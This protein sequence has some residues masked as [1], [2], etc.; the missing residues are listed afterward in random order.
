MKLKLQ[1]TQPP[2]SSKSNNQQQQRPDNKQHHPTQPLQERKDPSHKPIGG[3]S[4]KPP[5]PPPTIQQP[6]PLH[7]QL[8]MSA[9]APP[10]AMSPSLPRRAQSLTGADQMPDVAAT[11]AAAEAKS[12]RSLQ[13]ADS[14]GGS[15]DKGD[16]KRNAVLK[17]NEPQR[18]F[19]HLS[20]LY[21]GICLGS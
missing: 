2:N 9:A 21:V 1:Y 13:R 18:Y 15:G 8:S 3:S 14:S 7:R 5:K 6:A 10:P 4:G 11:V 16:G 19:S 20:F 12:R 17:G